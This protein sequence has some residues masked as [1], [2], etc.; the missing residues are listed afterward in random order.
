VAIPSPAQLGLTAARP[1]ETE[2]DW[3]ATRR[4]L[5]ELGAESFH[6]ERLS[7]GGFRFSCWLTIGVD[8]K[9]QRVEGQGATEAEAVRVTLDRAERSRQPRP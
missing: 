3:K 5:D 6:L 1:R 8:G 2:L 4:R 7:P 9:S